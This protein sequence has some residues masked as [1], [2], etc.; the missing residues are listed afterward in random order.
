M[1][2]LLALFTGDTRRVDFTWRGEIGMAGLLWKS[3][4]LKLGGVFHIFELTLPKQFHRLLI[5]G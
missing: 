5:N 2:S 4:R 3:P 1:M